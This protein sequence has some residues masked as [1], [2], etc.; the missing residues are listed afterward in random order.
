MNSRDRMLA[1]IRAHLDNFLSNDGDTHSAARAQLEYHAVSYVS[2]LL[3][4]LDDA[5]ADKQRLIDGISTFYDGSVQDVALAYL[6]EQVGVNA[7]KCS[8][9]NPR[10]HRDGKPPWC[11]TCGLTKDF[12]APVGVFDR[13]KDW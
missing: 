2:F 10:Q 4:E 6:L 11:H 13:R 3:R 8:D 5:N 7:D 9:H 1:Q 12:K